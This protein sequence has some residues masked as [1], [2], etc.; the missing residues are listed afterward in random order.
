[1]S[2]CYG[3][4]EEISNDK[5]CKYCGYTARSDNS[6]L[7]LPEGHVLQDRYIIGRVLGK[8]GGFGITYLG[9]NQGL[10]KLVAIK[11]YLPRELVARE[12]DRV[13]ISAHSK[14]DHEAFQYGMEQ[15][16]NEARILAKFDHSNIVRVLDYFE[17]HNTAYLVMNYYQGV[18]L[19]EYIKI[20]GGQLSEQ[21]VIGIMTPILDGLREVHKHGILHRDVKPH[22]IYLTENG[23]PILLDFGNARQALGERN[24]S[25]SVVMTPGFAPPEQYY[26]KGNQGAWTD[27][28]GCAATMYYML[29]GKVPEDALE[30]LNGVQLTRLDTIGIKLSATVVEAVMTGLCLQQE[31]RLRTVAEFQA[32]LLNNTSR[33]N[34]ENGAS[35]KEQVGLQGEKLINSATSNSRKTPVWAWATLGIA[36]ILAI[37]VVGQMHERQNLPTPASAVKTDVV[38]PPSVAPAQNSIPEA[39]PSNLQYKRYVNARYGYSGDYPTSFVM[40]KESQN[41]DGVRI[42]APDGQ[43]VLIMFGANNT[44][45]Q[46]ARSKYDKLVREK[47][48]KVGYHTIGENWY[49]VTWEENGRL[50]YNKT[51]VDK[52]SINTFEIYFPKQEKEYYSDIVTH[53]EGNFK[54]G[55]LFSAH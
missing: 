5:I 44:Q 6:N 45:G 15:F 13:S 34:Y 53:I 10:Q 9:Y 19:N 40:G 32:L 1:M 2:K 22:N 43:A 38:A 46:T 18:N 17:N 37:V 21:A 41:G 35:A 50:Y 30:R 48:N 49:V 36:I 12:N 51:L 42:T 20:N 33:G 7:L 23:R 3:C 8:P 47:G 11:E 31:Q 14:E 28:Y 39:S 25:L 54:P 29:T 24:V 55:N 4:F 52:G 26:R 16:L 27:I